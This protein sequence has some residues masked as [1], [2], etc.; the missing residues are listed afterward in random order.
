LASPVRYSQALPNELGPSDCKIFATLGKSFRSDT[1]Q[2]GFPAPW[3]N[4]QT[5]EAG[6]MTTKS[7]LSDPEHWRTRAEDAR[8]LAHDIK[9]ANTK[10]ALLQIADEYHQLARSGGRELNW[11]KAANCFGLGR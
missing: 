1:L 3:T 8:S 6:G 2:I 7:F 10:K 4:L 9:D 11:Q 5:E